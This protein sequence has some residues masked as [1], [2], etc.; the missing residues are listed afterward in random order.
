MASSSHSKA[1]SKYAKK[2]YKRFELKLR[3]DRNDKLIKPLKDK[4]SI[5]SYIKELIEKDMNNKNYS[6]SFFNFIK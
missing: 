3:K 1:N 2:T 4:P 6:L 5:N